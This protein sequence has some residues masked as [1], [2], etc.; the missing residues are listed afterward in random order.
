MNTVIATIDI[1][2]PTGRKLVRDLEKHT[3]VVSLNY[4][5]PD[6]I[7]EKG[8]TLEESY[9]MGLDKLSEHYGVDFKKL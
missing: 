5:T 4:P 6:N 3:K 9:N 7:S 1:S 8:Y 2:K